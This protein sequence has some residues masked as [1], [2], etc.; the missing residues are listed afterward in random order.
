MEAAVVR[1]FAFADVARGGEPAALVHRFMTT[2]VV[3]GRLAAVD[4]YGFRLKT[5]I[6]QQC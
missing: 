3:V 5:G 1:E 6:C 2:F 4:L